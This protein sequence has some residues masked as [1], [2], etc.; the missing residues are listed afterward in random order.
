MVQLWRDFVPTPLRGLQQGGRALEGRV[1]PRGALLALLSD[2]EL[3][4]LKVA[5]RRVV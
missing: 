3:Q 4:S 5:A 2:G 1:S